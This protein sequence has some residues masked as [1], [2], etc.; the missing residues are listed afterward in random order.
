M[1]KNQLFARVSGPWVGLLT[2]VLVIYA[3]R[4]LLGGGA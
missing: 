1:P 4:P 3:V 2:L